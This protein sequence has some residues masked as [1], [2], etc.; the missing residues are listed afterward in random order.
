MFGDQKV[1]ASN[2]HELYNGESLILGQMLRSLSV[3][4]TFFSLWLA[5][6]SLPRLF[7]P[8]IKAIHHRH[9]TRCVSQRQAD[10]LVGFVR[11]SEFYDWGQG[12]GTHRYISDKVSL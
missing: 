3:F 1:L 7:R 10:L 9:Q 6:F 2:R 12:P 4:H 5:L 11:V 8:H